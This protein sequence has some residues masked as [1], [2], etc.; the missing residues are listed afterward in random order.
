[1]IDVEVLIN[2]I[3]LSI[4]IRGERQCRDGME[5]GRVRIENGTQSFTKEPYPRISKTFEFTKTI[6]AG[7]SSTSAAPFDE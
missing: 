2:L 7:I 3:W 5:I 6:P 1:M 4:H